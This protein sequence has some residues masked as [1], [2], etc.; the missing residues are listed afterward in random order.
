VARFVKICGLTR[1][2]DIDACIR[3]GADAIGL[4]LTQVSSRRVEVAAARRL[5]A[6]AAS[7]IEVVFVIDAAPPVALFAEFPR[8]RVQRCDPAWPWT[9]AHAHRIEVV[10]LNEARDVAAA[11]D[12]DEPLLVCDA[13]GALG[14]SGRQADWALARLLAAKRTILLAG[15]LSPENVADAVRAV[16]PFGVDVAGGVETKPGVKDHGKITA[17]VAVAKGAHA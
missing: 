2:E 6:H 1:E 3:S 9:I 7:R 15:G 10:R 13:P 17:F 11:L 4:N 12:R 8:A 14:G 16:Q 5:A